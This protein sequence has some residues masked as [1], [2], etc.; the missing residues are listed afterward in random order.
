MDGISPT[1]A[2]VRVDGFDFEGLVATQR[3]PLEALA[4]RLVWDAEDAKDLVQAALVQ[5]WQRRSTLKDAA[6]APGWLR[7][8]VVHRAM[9]HLRRRRLW[10]G[11][12]RVLL[13]EPEV[14]ETTGDD[15]ERNQHHRRLAL[16]LEGLSTKQ[17]AAFSLRYLEGLS[18]DEVADAMGIDRGTVRVHVQRAVKALREQGVLPERE[19]EP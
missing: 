13:V 5:A 8:I 18:L 4:R 19:S 1:M 14:V 9:S 10:L 7:R 6:A 16:A 15:V 17:R 2:T 11:L 3:R 12:S